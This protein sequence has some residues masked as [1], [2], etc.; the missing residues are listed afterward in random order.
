M[1]GTTELRF[2]ALQL[3]KIIGTINS[4]HLF[5]MLTQLTTGD[6]LR[7]CSELVDFMS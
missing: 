6:H 2:Q 5:V 3:I 4:E 1:L 7:N